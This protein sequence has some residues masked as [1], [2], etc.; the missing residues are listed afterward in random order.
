MKSAP[1][2]LATLLA[3]CGLFVGAAP[4][5]S[6]ATV[7]RPI[8]DTELPGTS[9]STDITVSAGGGFALALSKDGVQ[10]LVLDSG[11]PNLGMFDH[12]GLRQSGGHQAGGQHRLR[13]VR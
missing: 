12:Q 3:S 1:A 6:A 11:A 13:P 9:A 7:L 2:L 4:G 5:A 8:A 10:R